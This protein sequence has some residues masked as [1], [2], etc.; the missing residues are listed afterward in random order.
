MKRTN[1]E[2]GEHG[3]TKKSR[4]DVVLDN[5]DKGV[6]KPKEKLPLR[7]LLSFSEFMN[8]KKSNRRLTMHDL[9]EF[10][11]QKIC[12][13]IVHKSDLGEVHHQLKMQE[14]LIETMRKEL[15]QLTKQARDLEIVN[16]KLLN[17]LKQQNTT[18]KPL[19][20]LKIT[21]SVGLQVKFTPSSS[22]ESTLKRRQANAAA[23]NQKTSQ[24]TPNKNVRVNGNPVQNVNRQ[25]VSTYQMWIVFFFSLA[26]ISSFYL[27]I[28]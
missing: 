12:E 5:E 23:P 26:Q 11:I 22:F 18:Q 1:S 25:Q 20:P 27:C 19:N 7:T 15:Q 2:E 24:M 17:D 28:Y 21:R 10:C 13:V 9:E 8:P 6:E 16:K 3:V 4:T 14:Q